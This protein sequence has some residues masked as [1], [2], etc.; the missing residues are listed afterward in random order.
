M[1]SL[2]TTSMPPTALLSH[3]EPRFCSLINSSCNFFP[4]PSIAPTSCS[5][6]RAFV[7]V[8]LSAMLLVFLA[9]SHPLSQIKC[10]FLRELCSF[11]LTRST[12]TAPISFILPAFICFLLIS[13][14][15]APAQDCKSHEG[16]DFVLFTVELPAPT[17][18]PGT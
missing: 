6:F 8:L 17:P 4:A 10:H 16:R 3:W 9:P 2:P 14:P 1:H 15:P 12:P 13:S 5:R 7:L 11:Y 18:V